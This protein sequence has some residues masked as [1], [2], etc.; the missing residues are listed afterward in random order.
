MINN[1]SI[2]ERLKQIYAVFKFGF[3]SNQKKVDILG[4]LII[5]SNGD[6]PTEQYYQNLKESSFP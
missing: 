5:N 3:K 1:K 6:L 4:D 2:V